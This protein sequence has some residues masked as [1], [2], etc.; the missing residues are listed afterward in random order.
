M[1]RAFQNGKNGSFVYNNIVLVSTKPPK[2]HMCSTA[3][4]VYGEI[5]GDCV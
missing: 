4:E 5:P 1:E 3:I 2:T